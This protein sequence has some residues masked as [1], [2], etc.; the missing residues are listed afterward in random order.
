[1]REQQVEENVLCVC[2]DV[3]VIL[4]VCLTRGWNFCRHNQYATCVRL[5]RSGKKQGHLGA[6]GRTIIIIPEGR[7]VCDSVRLI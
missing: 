4:C 7:N 1:M 2:C 5:G 3:C 6:P